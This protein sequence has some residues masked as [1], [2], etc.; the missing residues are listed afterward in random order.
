MKKQLEKRFS[1]KEIENRFI[2]DWN[3][4]KIFKFKSSKKSDPFCIMMPPPNVTGSLHMGH[5]LTFTLQDILIRFYKKLGKDVLWQ[6]GTDHAGIATEIV[7]EKQIIKESGVSKK[8][9]GREKFLKKIWE[10]KKISG[11]KIVDQLKRLGTS[12]DWSIS[13]FTMDEDLSL[14]VKKVFIELFNQGLIYQDK[15]LVNWDTV[16]ETAV[17]DLEVNQK[18]IEGTLWFIKYKINKNDDFITVATTRPETMFGDTAIAIHPQNKKLKKYIGKQAKIPFS[19]KLIPIIADKYADPEKGSGAVKITPAHDFND[20]KIGKKHNLDF[21]NIFD[22]NAKLNK[23][24]P[25]I[26]FGLDRYEARDLILE[27]LKKSN[28]LEKQMRNKMII[29][30]GDRSGSVIEPLMTKQ[31]FVDSKTLCKDV[32]K[33][34]KKN[35]LK[36]FPSSWMNTFKYWIDNIEPWC[37]SRQIWWGHR[38]PV[39][40]SNKNTKIAAKNIDEAKKILKKSRPNEK[41]SHQDADVLDTWFSSALWPFSTLGWPNKIAL[42]NKY[43]PTNVLVTGFDIIFFWVARMVM[44]GLFFI[45]KIPFQNIY[46]HPLV[47]DENGEK[48]SKSKGNVIDPLELIDLYGADSLRFTLVNLSTQG[49]DI[50]LSN[51]LV[52]NSRNFIT[53]L[54]NVAR[55]SQ[56][57]KFSLSKNYD[58]KKN[59]LPINDWILQRYNETQIKVIKHLENFKFNLLVQ[60]LYRFIWDDFCDVYIELSKVYLKE[61]K[62]FHEISNNFSY[63]FKLVLNLINPVIPFVSEKISKDLNYVK[64]SLFSEKFIIKNNVKVL[65]KRSTEFKKIIELIRNL[66]SELR[67]LNNTKFDLIIIN[68]SRIKWI[69]DNEN[70]IKLFFKINSPYYVVNYK[71]DLNFVS[72]GLKFAINY[73]NKEKKNVG[74]REKK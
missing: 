15:R 14:S 48:M 53:K 28:L 9:I 5:A 34:I 43:Y 7:V 10:W 64:S 42:L 51:K 41:I 59:K 37:I 6:P 66:R 57:N 58:F 56:F 45:K 21:V 24:V 1:F 40:Y 55:F 73:E 52:E 22:K 4:K 70:L 65:K 31:W 33:I 54:W 72:S 17:S 13:R 27:F 44:M 62:N 60:E 12:V 74:E 50:K 71:G 32:K 8:H 2:K 29:P 39:W 16:L 63:V 23:N 3:K 25:K 68:K 18:E 47:R 69:D 46:I 36:F 20:F 11:N 49:R 67:N 30:I 26:F 35:E 19:E 38:I 61:K